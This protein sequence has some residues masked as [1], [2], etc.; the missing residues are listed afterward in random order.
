MSAFHPPS[1]FPRSSEHRSSARFCVFLVASVAPSVFSG[2]HSLHPLFHS[3][4]RSFVTHIFFVTHSC[5]HTH[6]RPCGL[7]FPSHFNCAGSL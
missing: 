6:S 4:V 1:V 3:K 5:E 2:N 7:L